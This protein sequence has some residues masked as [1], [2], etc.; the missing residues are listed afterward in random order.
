L[1]ALP[2][3]EKELQD[4]AKLQQAVA[5]SPPVPSLPPDPHPT[6][7]SAFAAIVSGEH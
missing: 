5:P 4:Q 3:L 1:A 7:A 2:R 6:T